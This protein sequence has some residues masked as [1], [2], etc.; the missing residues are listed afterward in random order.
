MKWKLDGYSETGFASTAPVQT[1][2]ILKT[3]WVIAAAAVNIIDTKR[4]I[5]IVEGHLMTQRSLQKL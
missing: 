3:I 1:S 4:N 2:Q 5:V